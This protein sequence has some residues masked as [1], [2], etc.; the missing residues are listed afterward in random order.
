MPILFRSL[1]QIN[2]V[3]LTVIIY[4]VGKWLTGDHSGNVKLDADDEQYNDSNSAAYFLANE[5]VPS[6]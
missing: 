3:E 1:K 4:F 5:I 2:F 6:M